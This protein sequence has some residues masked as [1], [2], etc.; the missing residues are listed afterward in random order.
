V[1][2]VYKGRLYRALNPVYAKEPLA[3]EGARRFG[4]R[5]NPLGVP[6]LYCSL[7][8]LTSVREAN[9]VGTL[10]PTTLVSYEA[11]IEGI[12]DCADLAALAVEGLHLADLSASTWRDEMKATGEAKTQTFARRL[13]AKGYNGLL[14]QSFAAGASPTDLNLV[15]WRWN[16]KPT[17][18]I[19]LIDDEGRLAR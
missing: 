3:G 1:P 10:Q 15:L 16:V 9:Q 18:Q 4:G 17:A 12:F 11:N 8:I 14:V 19:T 7:S 13:I 2:V 6:A 5:F